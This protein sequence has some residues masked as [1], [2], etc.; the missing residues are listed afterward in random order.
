MADRGEDEP[1]PLVVTKDPALAQKLGPLAVLRAG[2]CFGCC[3]R[4]KGKAS[5][6]ISPPLSFCHNTREASVST[7]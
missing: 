6:E 4:H 3:E 2:V 1:A 5:A 7:G